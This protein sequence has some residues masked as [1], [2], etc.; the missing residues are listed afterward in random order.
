M[1]DLTAF[2]LSL[3]SFFG[4]EEP[5]PT[6]QDTGGIIIINPKKPSKSQPVDLIKMDTGGIII[7]KP[8]KPN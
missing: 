1:S 4:G 5:A 8:K 7:I 6:T 2:F 3:L